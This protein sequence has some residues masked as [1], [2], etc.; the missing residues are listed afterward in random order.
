LYKPFASTLA[1]RCFATKLRIGFT[2]DYLGTNLVA[3][4]VDENPG[5]CLELEDA[6]P[7]HNTTTISGSGAYCMIPLSIFSGTEHLERFEI[8]WT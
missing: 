4:M 8:F 1:A 3:Q 2:S 5:C 6:T 7:N